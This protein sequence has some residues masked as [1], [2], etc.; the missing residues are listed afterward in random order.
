MERNVLPQHPLTP[1]HSKR[2]KPMP[3]P[4]MSLWLSAAHTWANTMRAFWSAELQRQ[5]TAMAREM[6]RQTVDFWTKAWMT[7]MAD[8]SKRRR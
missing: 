7:P 2:G 5:Q 1:V 8:R 4:W 3:N 6:T